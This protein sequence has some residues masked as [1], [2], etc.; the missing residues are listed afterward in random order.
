[1]SRLLV[2]C[3]VLAAALLVGLTAPWGLAGESRADSPSVATDKPDYEPGETATITGTGFEPYAL[4][5][6]PVIRPDDSVVTGDGTFT[7]GWHSITVELDGSFE[8]S[9]QLDGIA[10]TY[11]VQVYPTPWGG[12]DS[13]EIPLATTTFA[14]NSAVTLLINGDAAYTPSLNVTLS[15]TYSGPVAPTQMRFRNQATTSLCPV[16]SSASGFSAWEA[17][18]ATKAWSLEAG[19]DDVRANCTQTADGPVGSPTDIWADCDSITFGAFPVAFF[20]TFE[21]CGNATPTSIPGWTDGDGSGSDCRISSATGNEY[22][23]LK[24]ATCAITQT[25][26]STVGLGSVHLEYDWAPEGTT[27][28]CSGDQLEVQW[29]VA[30]G[31]FADVPG[32]PHDLGSAPTTF[33]HADASLPA[34]AD[35]TTIEIRFLANAGSGNCYARVD[36]VKVQ[37]TPEYLEA[38]VKIVAQWV[39]GPTEIPVS[40]DVPIVVMETIHNN[41]FY[42]PVDV[43]TVKTPTVPPDCEVTPSQHVEQIH[44]VPVSVDVPLVEPFT[45]HC[46]APSWHTFT[47]DNVVSLKDPSITD[48]DLTNN[49]AH[50]EWTVPVVANADLEVVA[51]RTVVWPTDVDVSQDVLVTLETDVRNNGPYGPVEA[52]FEGWLVPTTQ[53]TI[54]PVLLS[55]QVMLNAGETQTISQQ[56]TIHCFE[57]C[58]Q[59]FEFGNRI[60]AKDPHID[61]PEPA[62]NEMLDTLPSVHAWVQ[63]DVAIVSQA[64]VG[65]PSRIDVSTNVDVTLRKTLHD[66][67]PYGPVDVSISP[68]VTPPPD[69]TAVPKPGNPT[70]AS[71][72]LPISTNVVVDEVWTIHCSNQSSHTFSFGDSIAIAPTM[73]HVKDTI[74][75]NNSAT[76]SL[77][78]AAYKYTDVKIVSQALVSPPTTMN[79]SENVPVTLH[80]VLHNNGGFGPV[81]VGITAQ[82][83]APSGCTATPSPG[84]PTSATLPVGTDVSVDEV[85]TLHCSQASTHVFTFSDT[86]A[87][88][89]PHVDDS[90]PGNNSAS[91][92][93]SVDVIAEADVGIVSQSFVSPPTNIHISE[94]VP[95]TLRK[96]LHNGGPYTAEAVTVTIAKTATAPADCTIDPSTHSQQ[97]VAP[98]SVDVTVDE[99][100]TIHCSQPTSHTFTVANAVS[101]PK[102][103]HIVDPNTANNGAST[104]LT[105]EVGGLADVKV[106]DQY[107]EGAPAEIPVSG[108]VSLMLIKVLHNNGPYGPVQAET[109]TDVTI[110][111][112]CTVSPNPH[113]QRFWNVPV[114][115]DILHHEPFV[116]HCSQPSEHTFVFDD[117]VTLTDPNAIDPVVGN[118]S[119]VTELTVPAVAQADVKITSAG[120]VNPPNKL[121]LG[122]PMD[123]TLRKHVHNNGPWT[124]VDIGIDAA[125]TAP[126]GC[127]VAPKSVPTS[128]TDVPVS[129]DQVVDEVWTIECTDTGLKT[130]VFDNSLDVATPHVND[131]SL[132]N[133]SSHKLLSVED[134]ATAELDYDIDGL[135]DSCEQAAGSSITRPDTDADGVSDG[136]LDPDGDGPIAAG[137]DNCPLVANASQVDYD[138]DGIGDACETDDSDADGFVDAVEVYLPTDPLA[139]CAGQPPHDAWPLDVNMDGMVTVA[140]DVLPYAG[141]IGESDGPPPSVN[142]RQRL[143]LNTDGRITVAGDVLKFAGNIGRICG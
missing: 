98:Y 39:E 41:G 47:F 105:V 96:V 116:I 119:Q 15:P 139:S 16:S 61:D 107:L 121:P 33:T 43:Q 120:F 117:E 110:P 11:T 74:L 38:D 57:K 24:E 32:S 4:L 53:C 56:F 48:P 93:H 85:W 35:N 132:S 63:A 12:P 91:T 51:Q 94:N 90:V 21:Q 29:R 118:N 28:E 79:V 131:P 52:E 97:V 2:V 125:A 89:T 106:A 37:G 122:Q 100:F 6:I 127:T 115:V 95:V 50:T 87:I 99:V 27:S 26:I 3:Y 44:N 9:Y 23:R 141:R 49:A 46:S 84:N 59:T 60:T 62:N 71:I 86:I 140:G 101:Q 5:D 81:Q 143:D 80:K 58:L 138:G 18:S 36:N 55:Q 20:D 82:A 128:L 13:G 66:N 129:V 72:P 88:T 54:D 135:C 19:L 123:I 133:N 78:V 137:P 142:W 70:S 136:L 1:M 124:P 92:S 30:A 130:F 67:G 17:Y 73:I 40:E 102:E 104:D 111:A 114:S 126:T 25:S 134:D 75:G 34:G 8:Y 69:C 103:P 65:P 45:I 113:I 22:A 109:V 14:D 112:D 68:S 83:Q 77:T 10:G 42:G 7:G 64:F 76:T 108:D 31:S